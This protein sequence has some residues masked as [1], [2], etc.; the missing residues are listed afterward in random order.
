MPRYYLARGLN[1]RET[2]RLASHLTPS[3]QPH[4]IDSQEVSRSYQA[5]GAYVCHATMLYK[6]GDTYL[7]KA[8]LLAEAS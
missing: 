1:L 4:R 3:V 8:P 6:H 7:H 5:G 2:L